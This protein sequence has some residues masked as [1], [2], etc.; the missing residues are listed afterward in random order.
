MTRINIEIPDEVHARL[1]MIASA[2]GKGFYEWLKQDLIQTCPDEQTLLDM[3][4]GIRK[5]REKRD[6]EH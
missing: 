2:E 5:D 4:R 6:S 3:L 1:K